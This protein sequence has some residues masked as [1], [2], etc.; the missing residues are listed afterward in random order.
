LQAALHPASSDYLYF[1]ADPTANGH[2]RFAKTLEE[3]Q[4]NV[5]AYRQAQRASSSR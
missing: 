3:H 5:A 4:R 2:S 1:V